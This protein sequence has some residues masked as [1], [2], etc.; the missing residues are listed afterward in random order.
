M[1]VLKH[2]SPTA[3]P[4][5]PRPAPL[6]TVPSASTRT[7]VA[8]GVAHALRTDDFSSAMRRFQVKAAR[9]PIE[10]GKEGQEMAGSRPAMTKGERRDG[11]VTPGHDERGKERWPGRSPDQVRKDGKER[12][13]ARGLGLHH[14]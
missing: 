1:A 12:K 10:A 6:M 3:E 4:S 7:A 14:D 8:S 9:D 5:A 13:Y 11:R 2:T